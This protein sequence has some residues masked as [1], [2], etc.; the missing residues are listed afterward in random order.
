MTTS[1]FDENSVGT[2]DEFFSS[3]VKPVAFDFDDATFDKDETSDE[4]E[5]AELEFED[6][7]DDEDESGFGQDVENENDEQDSSSDRGNNDKG[8]V[9]KCQACNVTHRSRHRHTTAEPINMVN[10]FPS[11]VF[12]PVYRLRMCCR[13]FTAGHP[14]KIR[15]LSKFL[16]KRVPPQARAWTPELRRGKR[17]AQAALALSTPTTTPSRSPRK[18][19]RQSMEKTDSTTDDNNAPSSALMEDAIRDRRRIHNNLADALMRLR[20]R[21]AMM[22][23]IV[24]SVA[25]IDTALDTHSVAMSAGQQTHIV[26]NLAN[27]SISPPPMPQPVRETA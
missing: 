26:T 24:G 2:D 1:I 19:P 11:H 12:P 17:T 9:F 6:D 7:D 5:T 21:L 23:T 20:A 13:W 10:A 25:P 3:Q 18:R 14:K 8:Y 16:V 15:Y 27:D 22:Q 4:S